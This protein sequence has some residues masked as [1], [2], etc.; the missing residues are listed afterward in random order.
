MPEIDCLPPLDLAWPLADAVAWR[1]L[2]AP[3][4]SVAEAYAELCVLCLKGRVQSWGVRK[5]RPYALTAKRP[6]RKPPE[7]LPERAE[8]I[9]DQLWFTYFELDVD[10]N[11]KPSGCL[12]SNGLVEWSDVVFSQPQLVSEWGHTLRARFWRDG[13]EGPENEPPPK[14]TPAR[15]VKKRRGRNPGDGKKD[16]AVALAHMF[17]LLAAGGVTSPTAAAGKVA[18]K[19]NEPAQYGYR[20]LARKFIS[21]YESKRKEG[22]SWCDACRRIADELHMKWR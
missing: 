19:N 20:R 22:E 17:E 10:G 21:E 7:N 16:D 5:A 14:A 8:P 12:R 9:H 3:A 11:G 13:I 15:L 6:T 1:R 18:N 4:V 2:R